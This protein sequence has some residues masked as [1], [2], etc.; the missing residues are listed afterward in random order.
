MK[1]I[2]RCSVILPTHNRAATLPR[3]LASVTAQD[4]ADFELIVV[5]DGSTDDTGA[6]LAKL[7]D[8][9]IRIAR[10]DHSQ[11]PS[12]ARNIGI[13]MATAPVL[14]FLDS[15]DSYCGNRISL[16]LAVLDREP[17]IIC[18]LSSARKEDAQ[19]ATSVALLPDVKL[20]SPAFEWAMICDLVGV[21]TTSI[22]VRT[23]HARRIGGFCTRLRRS[24]DR[25]FLI[26]LSRLGALRVL[27]DVLF[28]KA[29]SKDGLSNQWANDG[30][31]LASYL[32]ER[33]ELMGRYRKF[34][35]YLVTK[36]LIRHVRHGNFASFIGD[37]RLFRAMGLLEEGALQLCRNHIQVRRYRRAAAGQ[38]SLA[39]LTGPPSDWA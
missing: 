12:A 19:G 32:S 7:D 30:S 26:R 11:G 34:G 15:D 13:A 23:E 5:D 36:T 16:P 17:D 18:T 21:E 6:W 37:A 39:A 38:R 27:P 35:Q 31:E 24:E 3:T 28:A 9:R 2:P 4:E 8:P 25:E 22:T 1:G 10:S 29:W 20:A 14:A 33:P